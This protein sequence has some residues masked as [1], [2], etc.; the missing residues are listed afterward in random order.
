MI[1]NKHTKF[2]NKPVKKTFNNKNYQ[3]FEEEKTTL[4]DVKRNF[5]QKKYRNFNNVL[6]SKDIDALMDYEDD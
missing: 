6:R 2:D 5:E 4:R 3:Y 1:N